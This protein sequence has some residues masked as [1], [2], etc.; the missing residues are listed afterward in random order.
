MF[1]SV[2]AENCPRLCCANNEY[3]TL[4]TA[5]CLLIGIV[6]SLAA[7]AAAAAA[8]MNVINIIASAS[9]ATCCQLCHRRAPSQCCFRPLN[10]ACVGVAKEVNKMLICTARYRSYRRRVF[11][12]NHTVTDKQTAEQPACPAE[13]T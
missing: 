5:G 4:P 7:A 8:A 3:L 1:P 6:T 2:F 11:H 10:L 13:K 12:V 9:L